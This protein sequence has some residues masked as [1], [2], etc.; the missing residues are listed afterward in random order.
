MI[1]IIKKNKRFISFS[2]LLVIFTAVSAFVFPLLMQLSDHYS[3]SHLVI[4]LTITLTATYLAQF[5]L[6]LLKERFAATLNKNNLFDL[7]LQMKHMPYLQLS[8]KQPTYLLNRIFGVVDAYYLF[9]CG[10]FSESIR[11]LLLLIVSILMCLRI[12]LLLGIPLLVLIP[13]NLLGYFLINK[14]L[15]HRMAIMQ[16]TAA[17]T[18]KELLTSLNH[19]D[20]MKQWSDQIYKQLFANELESMYQALARTNIFAQSASLAISMVNQVAQIGIYLF[21]IEGILQQSLPSDAII[22]IGILMPIYFSALSGL[23]KVNL[24]TTTLK[25]NQRFVQEELIAAIPHPNLKKGQEI[26]QLTLSRP[27]IAL[28]KQF[29]Q[30]D[31][32]TTIL[33]GEHIYLCGSS[34]S[35]KSTLL[36][37]IAGFY[38]VEGIHLTYVTQNDLLSDPPLMPNERIL[39]L[40]QEPTILSRTIEQNITWGR[41]MTLEE[42]AY[43]EETNILTPL[44]THRNWD[45]Y[46]KENGADLSGG[47]KQRIAITRALLSSADILLLD[48]AT[49]SLDDDAVHIIME[50]LKIHAK[51]RIIIYTSHKKDDLAFCHRTIVI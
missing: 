39:Y 12:H 18:N 49:S 9:I 23:T 45:S 48:E 15:A 43:L 34:G 17:N 51:E 10:S 37:A 44:F 2:V 3:L 24:D 5:L 42:K 14:Q 30:F 6:I 32:D 33:K 41:P 8:K 38:P 27:N 35:G 46:L 29:F 19:I 13:L 26:A 47:E 25:T 31:I 21:V 36:K 28:E 40:A 22:L 4:L 11:G 1:A 16:K 50:A 7:L 20:T